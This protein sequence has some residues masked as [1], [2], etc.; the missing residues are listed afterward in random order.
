MYN[1][2]NKSVLN[3]NLFLIIILL[4]FYS[5]EKNIV[6][7]DENLSE[8]SYKTYPEQKPIENNDNDFFDKEQSEDTFSPIIKRPRNPGLSYDDSLLFEDLLYTRG[9][10]VYRGGGVASMRFD[11]YFDLSTKEKRILWS[12][13]GF[14]PDGPR[15]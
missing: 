13:T 9:Y 11:E 12:G 8:N 5:C 7:V 1:L 2:Q 4:F 3:R 14:E 6:I 15:I 10:L